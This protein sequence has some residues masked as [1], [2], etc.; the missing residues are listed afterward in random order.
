MSKPKILLVGAGGHCRACI[1]VVEQEGRF[2]IAGIVDR[3]L[4]PAP[5][6][7]GYTVI[8]ADEALPRLRDEYAFALVTVGQVKSSRVRRQLF[9][10]L[11]K[12]GFTLPSI[13]SPLAHVS[14]H[15]ELGE[16]TIV[17]HGA[18]VNAGTRIGR[19]CILNSHSLVEH[20]T[21]IDDHCHISTGAIVNGNAKVGN[22][23]FIGSGAVVIHGVSVLAYSFV[24]S[25]QLVISQK[26]CQSLEPSG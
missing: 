13:V 21:E 7:L 1:D 15:A 8:A 24:R 14:P 17:M 12:A 10:V 9:S 23:S 2:E 20:D 3:E 26:D 16:G 6:L 22:N 18:I 11:K 25:G 5:E 4:S 19:N